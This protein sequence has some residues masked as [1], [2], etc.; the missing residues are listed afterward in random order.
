MTHKK[1]HIFFYQ[2]SFYIRSLC[3]AI[4]LE[5]IRIILKWKKC[6]FRCQIRRKVYT[7][8]IKLND[9]QRFVEN[10][11]N[12]VIVGTVP[13]I[14][15]LKG[16]HR[17]RATPWG[18]SRICGAVCRHDTLLKRLNYPI[19]PLSH[20]VHF[21]LG[22]S[23]PRRLLVVQLSFVSF[24]CDPS[25]PVLFSLPSPIPERV[26]RVPCFPCFPYPHPLLASFWS[27]YLYHLP[28]QLTFSL[29]SQPTV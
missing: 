12:V 9:I 6:S 7:S 27:T 21:T 2:I 24:H 11:F 8:E 14:H 20:L 10:R 18:G 16:K 4:D 1:H 17:S 22:L 26:G 29:L 19:H 5:G 3:P 23:L 13:V 28:Q 25:F 15:F